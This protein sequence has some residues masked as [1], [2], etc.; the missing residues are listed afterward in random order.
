MWKGWARSPAPR[1][2]VRAKH[3]K[4]FLDASWRRRRWFLPGEGAI[5]LPYAALA[6]AP[7]IPGCPRG[8][9]G[10]CFRPRA[11][12]A[13][14][15]WHGW[16]S[17]GLRGRLTQLPP[18]PAWLGPR[19]LGLRGMPGAWVLSQKQEPL[20][21]SHSLLRP[22]WNVP[23]DLTGLCIRKEHTETCLKLAIGFICF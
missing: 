1:C 19:E 16:E 13:R 5:P 20:P 4:R 11:F 18:R 8:T 17:G 3:A 14:V 9:R 2:L 15:T 7:E 12:L 22:E 6:R 23:Q 21:S 10:W